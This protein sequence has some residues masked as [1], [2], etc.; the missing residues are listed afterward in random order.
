MQQQRKNIGHKKAMML[1]PTISLSMSIEA[2][3]HNQNVSQD[4][5]KA[6]YYTSTTQE[7]KTR[8]EQ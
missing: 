3:Y 2:T 5:H 1:P 7:R 8:R 4:L 6:R